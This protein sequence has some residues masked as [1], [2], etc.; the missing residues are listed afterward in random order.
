MIDASLPHT[1][2][3]L[4]APHEMQM[5]GAGVAL[6]VLVGAFGQSLTAVEVTCCLYGCMEGAKIPVN[7]RFAVS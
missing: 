4:D 7:N 5:I 1:T 6:L 3:A 2:A